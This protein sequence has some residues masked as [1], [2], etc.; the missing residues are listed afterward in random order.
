MNFLKSMVS[1]TTGLFTTPQRK[2]RTVAIRRMSFVYIATLRKEERTIV[3]VGIS[4]NV[5][6]R[7]STVV[8]QEQAEVIDVYIR[9]G[10]FTKCYSV[11][12]AVKKR[13]RSE[14]IMTA[15]HRTETFNGGVTT[16]MIMMVGAIHIGCHIRDFTCPLFHR[17]TYKEKRKLRNWYY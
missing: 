3:K 13:F 6:S 7:I 14:Q 2:I 1:P 4:V 16:P 10:S 8:A 12:L 17:H 15:V 11:E 5:A 9:P